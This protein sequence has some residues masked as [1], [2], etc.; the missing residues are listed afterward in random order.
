MTIQTAA[1]ETSSK[2]EETMARIAISVTRDGE[3]MHAL[4]QAIGYVISSDCVP[5]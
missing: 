2:E 4:V 5:V 3:G 1:A